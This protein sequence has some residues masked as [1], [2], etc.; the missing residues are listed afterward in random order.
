[1]K[2]KLTVSNFPF[3]TAIHI[4]CKLLYLV[5]IQNLTKVKAKFF[6]ND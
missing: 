6:H 1:M 5:A 2:I 3:I 4:A